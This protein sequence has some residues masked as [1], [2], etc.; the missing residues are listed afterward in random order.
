MHLSS[1]TVERRREDPRL[2]RDG[3]HRH[4]DA[5]PDA[6]PRAER[7][8][9]LRRRHGAVGVG[10][11]RQPRPRRCRAATDAMQQATVNLFADMGAQPG[12]LQRGSGRGCRSR[13]TPFAPDL[14]RHLAGQWRHGRQRRSRDDHRHRGR[15]RRRRRPASKCRSTAAP[16]GVPRRAQRRGA[17][18]GR[19]G[20]L[21]SGHD[22][23]PR[24]S[25]TA[26]TVKTPGAGITVS[27]VARAL[28]VPEPL[29]HV[30]GSA[31]A[32]RRRS[33]PGRARREIP[34]RRQRLRHR[35]PLLQEHDNTGT[36]V[37]NLWT[38]DRH[39]AGHGDLHGR[40]GVG[41]AAG[42]LRRA[43]R[44]SRRTRPTSSRI[45]P[46]SATTRRRR[47]YFEQH[48][49]RRAAAACA[50]QRRRRRQRRLHVRAD[51]VSRRRHVQRDQLLG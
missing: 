7:R 46:T 8:A 29:E 27:V 14:D 11:R 50:D 30:D 25:T 47:G 12:S 21:G 39:A 33:E 44:R 45:T 48:R 43:G 28:P 37:G 16:P 2:R 15:Q 6:L 3:R 10:P 38:S 32:R 35:R 4:G 20:A 42:A 18:T 36:H 34:Q 26:A 1:T 31:S 19:P 23:Q 24:R 13:P 9:R 17:S 49:R 5:S 40:N 22:P 51:G 41:L